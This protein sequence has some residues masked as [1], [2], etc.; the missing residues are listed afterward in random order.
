M[1][2]PPTPTYAPS[3]NPSL[4]IPTQPKKQPKTKNQTKPQPKHET[5]KLLHNP[6]PQKT[7]NEKTT[8]ALSTGKTVK[9]TLL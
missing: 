4:P 6:S 2:I 9:T 1:P 8:T 5:G 3:Q 7:K